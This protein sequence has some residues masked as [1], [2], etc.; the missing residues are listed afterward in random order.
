MV[1]VREGTRPSRLRRG[2]YMTS[3]EEGIKRVAELAAPEQWLAVLV[4]VRGNGEPRLLL[5]RGVAG[6]P[7]GRG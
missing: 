7:P 5:V 6:E 2:T 1:R 4:T 3:I